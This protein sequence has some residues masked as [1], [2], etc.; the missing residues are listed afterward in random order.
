MIIS[1]VVATDLHNGIGANNDL[2]WHL[3]SDMQYFKQ[4]TTG[5]HVLM[6]RNTYLSIPEKYR[7]LVDRTNLVISQDTS[8]ESEGAKVFQSIEEGVQF[9]AQAGE[10]ELMVIGGGKIYGSIF[11]QA[12]RIYLTRVNHTF[13]E[14]D[15]FFPFIEKHFWHLKS[16]KLQLKN[17]ANKYDLTYEVWER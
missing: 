17:E 4:I 15:T 13:K 3:P 5:H 14:A 9:A 2:L 7:P 12:N 6:G 16:S 11:K 8:F 10:N 1:L